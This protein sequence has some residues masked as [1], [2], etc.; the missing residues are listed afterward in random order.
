MSHS[1]SFQ[2]KCHKFYGFNEFGK[3]FGFKFASFL[4]GSLKKY[5]LHNRVF[6]YV[7]WLTWQYNYWRNSI[8]TI[9]IISLLYSYKSLE[10][11][12]RAENV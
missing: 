1:T 10:I 7:N 2:W 3:N 4:F 12:K 6:A 9:G 5:P 11:S 8:V